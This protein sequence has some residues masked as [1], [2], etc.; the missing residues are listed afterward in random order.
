MTDERKPPTWHFSHPDSRASLVTLPRPSNYVVVDDESRDDMDP[1][2]VSIATIDEDADSSKG[3]K[4]MHIKLKK[5]LRGNIE[6]ARRTKDRL[7][8]TGSTSDSR[9]QLTIDSI[10]TRNSPMDSYAA[11]YKK[12]LADAAVPNESSMVMADFSNEQSVF[13]NLSTFPCSCKKLQTSYQRLLDI[14]TKNDDLEANSSYQQ[15]WLGRLAKSKW[16][17]YVSALLEISRRCADRMTLNFCN[18]YLLGSENDFSCAV[19]SL[20][21]LILR[22]QTR[23]LD[24]ICS[25]ICKEWRSHPFIDR[26]VS[27]VDEKRSCCPVS[28]MTFKKRSFGIMYQNPESFE[29]SEMFLRQSWSACVS[30][31]PVINANDHEDS[32]DE[33]MWAIFDFDKYLT[34]ITCASLRN[35]LY[36]STNTE[37]HS[38]L[39]VDSRLYSMRLWTECFCRRQFLVDDEMVCSDEELKSLC[40]Q[41]ELAKECKRKLEQQQVPF[42]RESKRKGNNNDTEPVCMLVGITEL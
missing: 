7:V 29:A 28:F 2:I 25:L 1:D 36:P 21:Q 3:L 31:Y 23:S 40:V 38:A 32:Q 20:V 19:A 42:T 17:H 15:Q 4:G 34:P 12:F 9:F 13:V 30:G 18:V 8:S 37:T 24:G 16:L 14:C 5:R 33:P 26:L 27:F 35:P 10:I 6:S 39:Q 41:L 22:P 11:V